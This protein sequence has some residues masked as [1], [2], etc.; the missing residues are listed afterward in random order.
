MKIRQ[1]GLNVF[2]VV[3]NCEKPMKQ[4]LNKLK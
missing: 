4:A 3:K 2:F 1:G